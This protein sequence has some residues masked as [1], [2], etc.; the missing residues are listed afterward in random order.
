[1]ERNHNRYKE[2]E[3]NLTYA[4]VTDAVIFVLYLIFAGAG[5]VWLKV[6][7]S[8]LAI[9]LSGLCL[10]TLYISKELLRQRSLWITAAAAA[11]ILCTIVSLLLNYPGK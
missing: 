9:L 10:Y 1:M 2:L 11:I 7:T 4:I 5:I 6:I 3:R 8:I